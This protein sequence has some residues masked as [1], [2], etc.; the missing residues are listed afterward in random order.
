MSAFVISISAPYQVWMTNLFKTTV[1]MSQRIQGDLLEKT[2]TI[3]VPCRKI[4]KVSN[5]ESS[6]KSNEQKVAA[7]SQKTINPQPEQRF[8][9]NLASEPL[10]AKVLSADLY[11][12]LLYDCG[13][14]LIHEYMCQSGLDSKLIVDLEPI[15]FAVFVVKSSLYLTKEAWLHDKQCALYMLKEMKDSY[16][17]EALEFLENSGYELGE[18]I[19]ALF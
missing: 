1:P 19:K 7:Q 6:E 3:A 15:P 12:E 17:V 16:L 11:K 10:F 2:D 9:R 4:D 5:S 18:E 13:L 14:E 8:L